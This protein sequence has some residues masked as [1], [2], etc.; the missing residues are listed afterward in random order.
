M[1]PLKVPASPGEP[2]LWWLFWFAVSIV[3]YAVL[4]VWFYRTGKRETRDAEGE[5]RGDGGPAS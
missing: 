1:F 2:I 4:M 3:V 5:G